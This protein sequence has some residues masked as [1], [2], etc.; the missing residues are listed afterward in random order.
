MAWGI[1]HPASATDAFAALLV[2]L[3]LVTEYPV[4]IA[5]DGINH[6]YEQG[7]HAFDDKDVPPERLTLQAALQCL[8]PSGF[9]EE[10]AMARGVW[11]CAVSHKHS[12]NVGAMF[13]DKADVK[14]RYR[15][16][17][18][19]LTRQE[20]CSQLRH[21]RDTGKL[22]MLEGAWG[23]TCGAAS[24]PRR[25]KPPNPTRPRPRPHTHTARAHP[26]AGVKEIDPFLVEYFR[27]MSGG[28]PGEMLKC[29]LFVPERRRN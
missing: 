27:T 17:V 26:T 25:R 23:G 24:P 4:L 13:A 1:N 2:E 9:K 7:P 19:R 11:L 12:L 22:F 29:S 10:F 20:V 5:V 18:P 21:Y 8:G 14:N 16:P 6:L 3:R 28:V 15:L